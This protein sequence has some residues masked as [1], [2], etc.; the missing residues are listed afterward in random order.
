MGDRLNHTPGRREQSTPVKKNKME[1][2]EPA[3]LH[4][5]NVKGKQPNERY[6]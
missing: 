6:S 4:A 2:L 3:V 1:T 5:S